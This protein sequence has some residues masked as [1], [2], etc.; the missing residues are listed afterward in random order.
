MLKPL[1]T[2]CFLLISFLTLTA[3]P[4]DSTRIIRVL[5][6]NIYHG[7]TMKGDFDLDLIAKV[8]KSVDPDIVAL[9]EVDY[10]TNRARKMDLATELGYRTKMTPL[11]GRAMYYDDG[12]YGEAILSKYTF[13]QT[14]NHP[15]PYSEGKEPRALLEATIVL[16]SG[17]TIRFAGTH[18]DHTKNDYDRQNQ[19]REINGIYNN[20]TV[21]TI[22]AG[23][24]NDTITS[25]AMKSL[26]KNWTSVYQERQGTY[27]SSYA[28]RMIDYILFR[29]ANKWRVVEKQIICDMW[30]SDHCA[31]FAVLELLD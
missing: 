25:S 11:F 19:A 9:Q 27:P 21:P 20:S 28:G 3:Q 18:L 6:Y 5:T 22:L 17:D 8:I 7:E 24:L 2:I 4:V 29:P 1:S 12:E 10:K 26:F 13:L 14:I 16:E 15:L 30:A 31:V 23:D